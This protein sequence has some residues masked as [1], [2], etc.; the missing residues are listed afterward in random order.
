MLIRFLDI[1]TSSFLTTTIIHQV[2]GFVIIY[3]AALINHSFSQLHFL[4]QNNNWRWNVSQIHY[5]WWRYRMQPKSR[6]SIKLSGNSLVILIQKPVKWAALQH[7]SRYKLDFF[8]WGGEGWNTAVEWTKNCI[9][10]APCIS[11]SPPTEENNEWKKNLRWMFCLIDQLTIGNVNTI[12]HTSYLTIYM[13]GITNEIGHA[14]VEH[15]INEKMQI[16]KRTK[17][18]LCND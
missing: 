17:R 14:L 16:R 1:S 8:F 15:I 7:F 3:T 11:S 2:C 10:G 13:I 5:S 4:Y 9:H 18:C 12:E 6:K